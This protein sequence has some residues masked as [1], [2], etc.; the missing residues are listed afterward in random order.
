[1]AATL[2][3]LEKTL[4]PDRSRTTMKFT[5]SCSKI[6][7]GNSARTPS[8]FGSSKVGV[9]LILVRK[10]VGRMLKRVDLVGERARCPSEIFRG[11]I[12]FQ[13]GESAQKH[14]PREHIKAP[15]QSDQRGQDDE[16]SLVAQGCPQTKSHSVSRPKPRLLSI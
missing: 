16:E 14:G 4:R 5:R 3:P 7:E 10:L 9:R 6:R 2:K 15:H 1:M 12:R 13:A 8:G 11:E